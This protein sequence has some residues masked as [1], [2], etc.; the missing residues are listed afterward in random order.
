MWVVQFQI[1]QPVAITQTTIHVRH[2]SAALK[3]EKSHVVDHHRDPGHPVAARLLRPKHQPELP[4]NGQLDPYFDRDCRHPRH[5]ARAGDRLAP[6]FIRVQKGQP[7]GRLFTHNTRKEIP[8]IYTIVV[9]LI[10]LFV[11]GYLR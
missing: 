8:M 2:L 9:V 11:I 1:S 10:V 5:I 3:K 4:A 6:R 7:P